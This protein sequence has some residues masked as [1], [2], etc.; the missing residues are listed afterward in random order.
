MKKYLSLMVLAMIVSSCFA[1]PSITNVSFP[2]SAKLFDLYEIAFQMGDYSNPYDPKVIDVYAEFVGPNGQTYKVNGFYFEGYRF[3]H[4]N[5]YEKAHAEQKSNGWRVRFTPDQIGQWQFKL[6]AIDKKGNIELSSYQSKDFKF[7]CEALKAASGFISCANSQFLKRDVVIDGKRQYHSYFPIGPNVAW[8]YCK[9]YYDFSTPKG[10]YEYQEYTDSLAG[11]ANFMRIWMSR[12]QYLSL[13]GPEFTQTT[14]GKPTV[15][16]NSSLN[17]KDAAELDHIVTYAAQ[18]DID[19]MMCFFSFKEFCRKSTDEVSLKQNPGDWLNNPFHTQLGLKD[20]QDFFTNRKAIKITKNL[21]RYIAARWGYA[22]N[23]MCWELWN[24]M[25]NV[26]FDQKSAEPFTDE[27]VQWTNE[28]TTYLRS[29]DP[30]HHLVTT[31]VATNK[32]TPRLY[33]EIFKELDLAQR[34]CYFDMH[35]ATPKEHCALRLQKTCKEGRQMFPTMPFFFGEYAFSQRLETSKYKDK[36]PLGIDIHNSLWGSL[37]SGAAGPASFYYWT[38]LNEQKIF[39]VFKPM[40]VFSKVL[41]LLSDSFVGYNTGNETKST[42]TFPN[43]L[44]AYYL[45]NASQD[46]LLGWCQDTAFS[47]QSLRRL[48]EKTEGKAFTISKVFDSKGYLYTLN[49][50]KKPRPSSKSNLIS[51]PLERKLAGT[52]YQ[53]RWYDSETGMELRSEATQTTVGKDGVL[54]FEFPSSIRDVKK[55]RVNNT[56]GDA[57]FVIHAIRNDSL[58]NG[59][60]PSDATNSKKITVRKATKNGQH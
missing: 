3:E 56:Y 34:H 48:T 37:F 50:D 21:I 38:V 60:T 18:H 27:L 12:F 41:P 22:T 52:A 44:E 13:Y 59:G 6:R 45:M 10:I 8:Y 40:L 35:K 24:E 19:L 29:V 7:K 23:I 42:I 16:F 33:G 1:K 20:P 9:K 14:D 25:E 2:T 30:H 32:T 26:D 51:L 4:Y 36:D 11:K 5:G 46:T 17:Q 53:I 57:V 54:S 49:P 43:G 31:S 28:M 58:K 39:N 15:Y 47:Y 55:Q